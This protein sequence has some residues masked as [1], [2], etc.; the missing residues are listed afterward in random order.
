MI[1]LIRGRFDGMTCGLTYQA[2]TS[3]VFNYQIM[4]W[5]STMR[6]S[7][8]SLLRM[9]RVALHSRHPTVKIFTGKTF[10]R[11]NWVCNTRMNLIHHTKRQSTTSTQRLVLTST[12]WSTKLTTVPLTLKWSSNNLG[13]LRIW[14]KPKSVKRWSLTTRTRMKQILS[15]AVS[16]R[17]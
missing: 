7:H 6:V 17:P 5:R 2:F 10:W 14:Q 16:P 4:W 8:K 9:P 15:L 1:L 3:S 11:P 12:E 13:L